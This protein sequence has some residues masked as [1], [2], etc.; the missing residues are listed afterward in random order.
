MRADVV[1]GDPVH[2]KVDQTGS[3]HQTGGIEVETAG[4]VASSTTGD[5]PTVD[6]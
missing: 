2:L 5:H 1:P 6:G 4:P 3:D